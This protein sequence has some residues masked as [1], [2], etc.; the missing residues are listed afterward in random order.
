MNAPKIVV[1]TAVLSAL[2]WGTARASE[3]DSIPLDDVSF[4]GST[5]SAC[6]GQQYEYSSDDLKDFLRTPG[7]EVSL[8]SDG[9]FS[10]N[11]TASVNPTVSVY[12][13]GLGVQRRT[14]VRLDAG[15]NAYDS[16]GIRWHIE[17]V[18]SRYNGTTP[19]PSSPTEDPIPN[20]MH[21]M[22]PY[23]N[24]V[25]LTSFVATVRKDSS[26]EHSLIRTIEYVSD[27]TRTSSMN[28]FC[29]YL[30]TKAARRLDKVK[31]N[32]QSVSPTAP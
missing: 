19:C 16:A 12:F 10:N 18:D 25:K 31:R 14:L 4:A 3:T 21:A 26:S 30:K 15:G 7:A 23:M 5:I 1:F 27:G 32:I 13:P 9:A 22:T 2:G 24:D 28:K 29:D 8:A 17:K 11:P 6:G 20:C